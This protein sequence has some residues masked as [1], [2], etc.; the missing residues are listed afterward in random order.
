MNC[1]VGKDPEGESKKREE[2]GD[3]NSLASMFANQQAVS[4]GL[5][6]RKR[7]IHAQL[8]KGKENGS[9]ANSGICQCVEELQKEDSRSNARPGVKFTGLHGPRLPSNLQLHE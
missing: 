3:D 7:H 1:K 6:E 9:G 5:E 4:H 2:V 8:Q